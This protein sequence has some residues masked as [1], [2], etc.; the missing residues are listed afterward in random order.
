METSGSFQPV[1]FRWESALQN[2]RTHGKEVEPI[3]FDSLFNKP[4]SFH[5]SDHEQCLLISSIPNNHYYN[6][7]DQ[8]HVGYARMLSVR[9]ITGKYRPASLR[10]LVLCNYREGKLGQIY[11]LV[12]KYYNPMDSSSFENPVNEIQHCSPRHITTGSRHKVLSEEDVLRN[13]QYINPKFTTRNRASDNTLYDTY[14]MAQVE[15][16]GLLWRVHAPSIDVLV[17]NDI[18]MDTGTFLDNSFVHITRITGG[19]Q[20]QYNCTC[21]LYTT[22]LQLATLNE[23]DADVE[24]VNLRCCHIRFF[25]DFIEADL[26]LYFASSDFLAK[27]KIQKLVKASQKYIGKAIC[28][29]SKKGDRTNKFSVLSPDNL[30]CNF[31]HVTNGKVGCQSGTCRAAFSCSQRNVKYLNDNN[32]ICDH[33]KAMRDN[34]EL[35]WEA[36]NLLSEEL[37]DH[38]IESES[39]TFNERDDV[40]LENTNQGTQVHVHVI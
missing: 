33:L 1:V 18:N 7:G 13:L 23:D 35:W 11:S 25:Q 26:T 21:Q 22:L 12:N 32:N 2:F 34:I 24:A 27:S 8:S 17:M 20:V 3:S 19:D 15:G 4:N 14:K 40:T 6:Q 31:V 16:Q 29:L 38:D 28:K 39:E 30:S 37:E 9:D 36:P 10:N 5:L